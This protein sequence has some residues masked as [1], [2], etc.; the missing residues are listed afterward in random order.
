VRARFDK[1]ACDITDLGVAIGMMTLA[2][3]AL[4]VN[5]TTLRD[6]SAVRKRKPLG[7]ARPVATV[8]VR[9]VPLGGHDLRWTGKAWRCSIC[10]RSTANFSSLCGRKC[11]GSAVAIWAARAVVDA[12]RGCADGGGHLRMLTGDLLWCR[13]CGAFSTTKAVGLAKAC[14]GKPGNSGRLARLLRGV[15]PVTGADIGVPLAEDGDVSG[16]A[17]AA[18]RIS[19]PLRSVQQAAGTSARL[20]AVRDRVRAREAAASAG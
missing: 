17:R 11:E 7:I 3:N 20:A 5:G 19:P 10:K 8:T 2:A 15:H 6:S 12:A 4:V 14:T 13:S 1:A 18:V 9:P 16:F